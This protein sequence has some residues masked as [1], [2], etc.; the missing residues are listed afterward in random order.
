MS[1]LDLTVPNLKLNDG[2][3]IPMLGYGTGTAW[4]KRGE[5]SRTDQAAVDG[6]KSA[7]SL[8]YHHLD[9]AEST[10]STSREATSTSNANLSLVYKTE[11]ELGTAIKGSGVAR[12]K[13]FVTT[14]VDKA[15]MHDIESALKASLQK[16]QLD[17]VDL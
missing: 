4:A 7:I 10:H 5:E 1:K 12:D 9:G 13:L 8:G 2:N 15:N 6:V 3:A 16:L 14:K 17:Y 11:T